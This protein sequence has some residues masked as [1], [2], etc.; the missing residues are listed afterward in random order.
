M[1]RAPYGSW[2]SPI[3]SGSIASASIAFGQIALDGD[4]IYWLEMRP[5]EA[6]RAVIVRR[7]PD[8]RTEDVNPPP[9]NARTRVHEYGGGAFLVDNGTVYFSNF[10]DQRLYC[11]QPVKAPRALTPPLAFRYA[12]GVMDRRRGRLICV[13]EDHIV[14][15][16]EAINSIVALPLD[17]TTSGDILL[18][19][20]DFYSNP[21]LNPD[22]TRLAW[23]E[24]RHPNMPWDGTELWVGEFESGGSLVNRQLVAG[25]ASESVFQPEWSPD[26][27]LY[28]VSDRTGWWNLYRYFQGREI[29]SLWPM[30]ADFGRP[31]WSF[32]LS[33]FAFVSADSIVCSYDKD[34][35][36]HLALLDVRARSLTPIDVP[37]TE[38][39]SVRAAT[40]HV[41]FRAASAT[42]PES[43]VSLD[44]ATRRVD[45]LRAS[46]TVAVD[47]AY[48]SIPR[49]IEFETEHGLTAYAFYYAPRNVDFVGLP[50]EKPPLIVISHGGPTY[51]TTASFN[52]EIQ[53][54]TS[55]GFAVADVNYGGSTGHGR[56]YR[57]RMDG[58]WG[59]VDTDD[60]CN[61]ARHLA[62]RGEVDVDRLIIRGSSAGG[63]TTLCALTFRTVFKAGASYYGVSDLEASN[64]THKFE[65]RYNWRLV[66]PWPECRDLY[67]ARSPLFAVERLNCPIIFFQGLKDEVV[68]P[69]Q[70]E[71]MVEAMRRKGLAVAYLAFEDE[72]HGF[73]Q[74]AHIKRSLEAELYFY[75]RVFGF[76]LA[77]P[78]EAVPIENL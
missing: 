37:Y 9:F 65:S 14:D 16:P 53:F 78:V 41:V 35:V 71:M 61:A 10:A 63:Y 21:R 60:C 38:I 59:V 69:N 4:D 26:G 36:S 23:L 64:D 34:D 33:T 12:D 22:G 58:Q 27:T 18:A 75:S 39:A 66:G 48:L 3:T 30:Q 40:N 44:V 6:G 13:R 32:G 2:R 31:Q 25:G 29:E 28:F 11:Q 52:L 70:S 77:D 54:W 49:P 56:G 15:G 7:T 17:V 51:A 46:S 24:W 20:S 76:S 55:R 42:E 73:R 67:R 45:V 43:V 50:D 74:A 57:E 8:G 5:S 62:A 1:I 68:L 47:R 19:G 72:G